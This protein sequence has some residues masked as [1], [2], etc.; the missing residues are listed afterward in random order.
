VLVQSGHAQARR[1]RA[2]GAVFGRVR[3]M[4]DENGKTVTT[5]ARPFRSRSRGFPTCRSPART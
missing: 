1:H 4:T 3:A 5:R 2:R